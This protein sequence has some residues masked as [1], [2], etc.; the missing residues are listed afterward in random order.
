MFIPFYD[1]FPVNVLVLKKQGNGLIIYNDKARYMDRVG[2][3]AYYQIKTN[4]A[5]FKPTGLEEMIPGKNGKPN[6]LLFE[7]QRGQYAPLDTRNLETIYE[8]DVKGELINEKMTQKCEKGHM[9]KIEKSDDS[10]K[11]PYC[12]AHSH[13]MEN[14]ETM[15]KIKGIVGLKSIDED[16]ALW[17]TLRIRLAEERHKNTSWWAQNTPFIMF[18]MTFVLMIVLSYLFMGSISQT[19]MSVTNALLNLNGKITIAPPG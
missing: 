16:M 15:P 14:P 7:Y 9:F 2:Q 5:M 4:K 11:C 1:K 8:R 12:G 13:K 18:S 17:R 10:E 19:G 3:H 6:L